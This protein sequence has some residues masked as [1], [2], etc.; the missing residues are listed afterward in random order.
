MVSAP[1]LA[2][3]TTAPFSEWRIRTNEPRSRISAVNRYVRS[4]EVRL[5]LGAALAHTG[6]F[7]LNATPSRPVPRRV[8]ASDG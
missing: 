8:A 1:E 7:R 3:P 5:E 4:E 6:P 2:A